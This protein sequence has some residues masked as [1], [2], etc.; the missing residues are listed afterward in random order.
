MAQGIFHDHLVRGRTVLKLDLQGIGHGA[1]IR[2]SVILS[3]ARIFDNPHLLAQGVDSRIDSHRILIMG[4]RQL[5][6]DQSNRDHILQAMVTIRRIAQRPRLVDDPARRCL[7]GDGDGSD[8]IGAVFDLR[9]ELKSAFNG[10]LSMVLGRK[11]LKQDIFY[12]IRPQGTGQGARFALAKHLLKSPP[13]RRQSRRI[14]RPAASRQ[15]RFTHTGVRGMPIDAQTP[16]INP[17]L[18]SALRISA[19]VSLKSSQRIKQP[20]WKAAYTGSKAHPV[21]GT[22]AP[23]GTRVPGTVGWR[24]FMQSASS[25]A[26]RAHPRLSIRQR[27]AMA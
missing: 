7:G 2:R 8:M 12:H 21:P 27:R 9:I 17:A 11:Y 15:I 24:S 25:R 22:R 13:S 3:E 16:A 14:A 26:D 1:F 23:L 6:K 10:C 18:D 5:A 4:Y 19:Q 20:R